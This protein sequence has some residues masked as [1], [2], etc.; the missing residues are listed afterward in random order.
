MIT[1]FG[2][3][4]ADSGFQKF[5]VQRATKDNE[6]LDEY[7][8]VAFWSS[9]TTAVILVGAIAI[10]RNQ[11]ANLAG[12]P[13]LGLALLVASFSL[14]MTVAVS[15]Q[16][17][18]FHRRLEYRKIL[19]I[20]VASALVT[21]AVAVP[22]ALLGA[23][24][25]ALIAG[26]LSS[27]LVQAVAFT[28][29]SPWKPRLF[30]SF[31]VLREMFSLSGW[32]LLESLS[33]WMNGSIAIFIV[34]RLLN[35]HDLGLFRQP[36]LF[37]VSMFAVITAATTPVL[38]SALSRLQDT[39]EEFR[40]FFLKFQFH[41]SLVVLPV[42]VGAFFFRDFLTTA[43]F[44]KNWSDAALMFGVWG[45]T[46]GFLIVLSHYCSE[47][48]RALGRPQIS[49]LSQTLYLIIMIPVLYFAARD[50]FVTLVIA[51]G[52]VRIAQ[53]AINQILTFFVAKISFIH[54]LTNIR[55]PLISVLTMSIVAAWLAPLTKSS[56][57]WS[58]AGILICIL[59]Y[60]S[61]CLCFPR[62][63][64]FL[65]SYVPLHRPRRR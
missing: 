30:Y 59:V 26:I 33:I 36:M 31:K 24:F 13:G 21:L 10:F 4:L 38:F 40:E 14:P 52:L 48:Y 35:P 56:T 22:L 1:S 9:T 20:R 44:G 47:I 17:A 27:T 19:P 37:V 6:E 5:L 65:F 15:T 54:V 62:V 49:L 55:G 23:D 2:D 61:T 60:A 3:M 39:T 58:C 57:L 32:S 16:M 25:W 64:K 34:G 28:M 45:I 18:L 7:A 53:V 11:L 51:N 50:G 29:V 46:N 41:V 43:F 8:N 42:G 12:N 63:R